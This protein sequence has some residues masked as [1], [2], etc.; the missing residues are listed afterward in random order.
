VF[1]GVRVRLSM[2]RRGHMKTKY[3]GSME[4]TEGNYFLSF[5]ENTLYTSCVWSR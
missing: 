4:S 2:Q 1:G 3:T 5:G